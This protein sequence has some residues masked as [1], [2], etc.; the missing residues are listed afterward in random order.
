MR[1]SEIYQDVRAAG[2]VTGFIRVLLS[3]A[4]F[5]VIIVGVM[6]QAATGLRNF[7]GRTPP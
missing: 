2:S 3:E 4:V 7:A 6:Q 1:Y 5:L